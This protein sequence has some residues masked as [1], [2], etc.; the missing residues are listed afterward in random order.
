MRINQCIKLKSNDA[1]ER[2]PIIRFPLTLTTNLLYSKIIN[3]ELLVFS[4]VATGSTPVI[5]RGTSDI[6]LEDGYRFSDMILM[7]IAF[8]SR[9]NPKYGYGILPYAILWSS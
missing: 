3:Y 7:E 6:R 1:Y 8:R 9:R 2:H 4:Y 5:V